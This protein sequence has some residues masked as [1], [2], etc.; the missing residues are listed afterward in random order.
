M[1]KVIIVG[2]GVGPM[3][4][5]LLH[6]YII[7]QTKTNGT[8]QDHL[9]VIHISRSKEIP[10]RTEYLLGRTKKDPAKAMFDVVN[11]AYPGVKL[12]GG[13]VVVGIPCNT[14]HAPKI[15]NRFVKMFDGQRG[16][17]V[18]N[19]IEETAKLIK[20]IKPNSKK[21]GLMSTTGTRNLKIYRNI[22]EPLRY[23]IVEV[24]N[25]LQDELHDT[26]YNREFGIKAVSPASGKA[27]DRFLKYANLLM[28]EGAEAIIL[29]CTE[30]PLAL[31][32]KEVNGITLIDPMIAL[33]RAM[34]SRID[35]RKLKLLS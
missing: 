35:S 21:I 24:P 22:L 14:F 13:R 31:P 18:V 19:M 12:K 7:E 10:D 26:I 2:G 1:E 32:E 5:L 29:G 4:G 23:K 27:R 11:I 30:I 9:T 28:G 34:I 6:K 25:N 20:T 17:E 16:I 8:D 3:A 15:F 33:A